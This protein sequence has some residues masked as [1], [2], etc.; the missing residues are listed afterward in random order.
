MCLLSGPRRHRNASETEKVP[1]DGDTKG[2]ITKHYT[3]SDRGAALM[4]KLPSNKQSN[5]S[6]LNPLYIGV[7]VAGAC[8]LLAII[9]FAIYILRKQH[10]MYAEH[11]QK[12]QSLKRGPTH[13]Q[14]G[15]RYPTLMTANGQYLTRCQ[16]GCPYNTDCDN[17]SNGSE[18]R[19]LSQ[20]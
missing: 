18:S 20:V 4:K 12:V 14:D 5:S 1:P 3:S 6:L 13:G 7:P 15:R 8:V 11:F 19:L 17:S 9:I 2:I 10:E 16:N